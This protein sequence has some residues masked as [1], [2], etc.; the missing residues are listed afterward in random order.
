MQHITSEVVGNN[1]EHTN[2]KNPDIKMKYFNFFL[3][4]SLSLGVVFTV[5]NVYIVVVVVVVVFE[6]FCIM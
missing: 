6:E 3:S 2:K 1:T 5:F 4:P